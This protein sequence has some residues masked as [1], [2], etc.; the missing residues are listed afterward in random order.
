MFL[1]NWEAHPSEICL[2]SEKPLTLDLG[3]GH[4]RKTQRKVTWDGKV[5]TFSEFAI[6]EKLA[7]VEM[8]YTAS[9]SGDS[10][11]CRWYVS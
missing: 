5:K 10:L 9:F 2:K 7:Y 8:F 4:M 1:D 6:H 11:C 3:D